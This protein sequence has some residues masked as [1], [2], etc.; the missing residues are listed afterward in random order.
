MPK[1]ACLGILVADVVGK[2]IDALPARGTLAPVE[3][4]ELHVG[5]CAA[6]TGVG[7]ARLGVPV[8]VLG[9]VGTDGFGAF[10]TGALT[11]AGVDVRGLAQDAA[12]STSATMV[13]VHGDGERTFLHFAGANAQFTAG[14][15]CWPVLEEA[16]ILHVAGPFLMPQFIGQPCA[17][18]LKR[19]KAMGKT[20]TLDTVWDAS[21]QW[22]ETL[23]PSLPFVD[24]ILPS[25]EEAIRITGRTEPADIAAVF[26]D[27]GVRTVGLKMGAVGCYVRTADGAFTVPSFPVP[28][29]D[30]L[31]AG[32]AWA[33]GFLCGLAQGWDLERT[34]R[35]A[36]AVGACAVQKLGATTGVRSLGD[37]LAFMESH[38]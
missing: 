18:V 4:M 27:A 1:I 25:L 31:G 3:Q 23:A 2:T 16:G 28:A 22:M 7:L 6:N 9:K 29:V 24:Y 33:A 30:A 12:A 15:V 17:D 20:T 34:A 35:L 13:A 11:V 32:D 38:V 14:D 36:N 37:T 5:G 19:A 10:L 21:G 26:L 8:S